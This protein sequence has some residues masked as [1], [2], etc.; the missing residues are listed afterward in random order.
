MHNMLVNKEHTGMRGLLIVTYLKCL[1]CE[2]GASF[3]DLSGT[4]HSWVF[5]ILGCLDPLLF[6][7]VY[8][9]VNISPHVRYEK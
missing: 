5:H 9:G 1:P 6:S 7:F 8:T 4:F 3:D 2:Q